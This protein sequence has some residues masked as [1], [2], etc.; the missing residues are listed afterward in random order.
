MDHTNCAYNEAVDRLK[1]ML[2][3]TPASCINPTNKASTSGYSSQLKGNSKDYFSDHYT[4]DNYTV[5]CYRFG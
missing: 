1:K 3:D 5:S 4:T 2:S